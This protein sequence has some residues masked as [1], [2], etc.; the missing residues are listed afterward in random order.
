M[1]FIHIR[2]NSRNIFLCLEH[3]YTRKFH[4]HPARAI[5]FF[6][7]NKINNAYV[8]AYSK[9]AIIA[10]PA[11]AGRKC[12]HNAPIPIYGKR[13]FYHVEFSPAFLLDFVFLFGVFL[14]ENARLAALRA[15]F[16]Q[17]LTQSRWN[18]IIP[19]WNCFEIPSINS[20]GARS[21]AP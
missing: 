5:T 6:L 20:R 12:G 2:T 4:Y 11:K 10:S 18:I 3:A 21:S 7:A 19:K 1:P 17:A 9:L 14:I 16:A 15:W 8:Q 13:Y